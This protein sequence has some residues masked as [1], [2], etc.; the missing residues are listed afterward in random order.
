MADEID[1]ISGRQVSAQEQLAQQV[2]LA[3]SA[4]AVTQMMHMAI[5]QAHHYVGAVRQIVYA[6]SVFMGYAS[7]AQAQGST[8][9]ATAASGGPQAASRLG[10]TASTD[11]VTV[12]NTAVGLADITDPQQLI[13]YAQQLESASW[14]AGSTTGQGVA[15]AEAKQMVNTVAAVAAKI[16][17]CTSEADLVSW[18]NTNVGH[19]PPFDSAADWKA[20]LSGMNLVSGDKIV[21]TSDL[22]SCINL[23]RNTFR[24][25]FL[26]TDTSTP[27]FNNIYAA[28]NV[29]QTQTPG[30]AELNNL[31]S[32]LVPYLSIQ[33][34]FM[35]GL[36]ANNTVDQ[37]AKSLL[38]N[39]QGMP[40]ATDAASCTQ[41]L[42]SLVPIIMSSG[43]ALGAAPGDPANTIASKAAAWMSQHAPN[44]SL[45]FFFGDL[46]Q[47][48]DASQLDRA[49]ANAVVGAI[50]SLSI[51]VTT[52][53][54]TDGTPITV[55]LGQQLRG[56]VTDYLTGKTSDLDLSGVATNLSDALQLQST[57][58]Q[59]P[60]SDEARANN[61]RSISQALANIQT[62]VNTSLSSSGQTLSTA[63]TQQNTSFNNMVSELT[64]VIS[65]VQKIIMNICQTLAVRG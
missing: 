49:T 44:V 6:Q 39:I 56:A 47:S 2:H 35:I 58:P 26:S 37:M 55:D 31:V 30:V 16:S 13:A 52:G 29:S 25:N 20:V 59:N 57:D 32:G 18:L 4:V 3:R 65:A 61:I 43:S 27:S 28:L 60:K 42:E 24:S 21:N 41:F 23:L 12:I 1:R 53:Y 51:N 7:A 63:V 48:A 40:G 36:G 11:P 34:S 46:N 9:A 54:N 19:S 10:S 64:T 22:D 50:S 45:P 5:S 17:G 14:K 8:G 33:Q 38:A 15:A 62:Q